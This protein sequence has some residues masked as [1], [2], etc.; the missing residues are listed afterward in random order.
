MVIVQ[1]YFPITIRPDNPRTPFDESEVI[2]S[3]TVSTEVRE[4]EWQGTGINPE[5]PPGQEGQTPPDYKDLSDFVGHLT[6]SSQIRNEAIN[7]RNTDREERPWDI[8]RATVAVAIDGVWDWNYDDQGKVILLPDGRID[9]TYTAVSEEELA[10]VDALVKDAIGY[11]QD[12]GDSVTVRHLQKDRRAQQLEEDNQFRR[13]KQAREAVLWII[14]AIG[15]AL[16]I[17]LVV[18]IFM[19]YVERK[20]REREEELARQHAAMREAA[21]RSAEEDGM[22]V[23]LSI[24]DRARVEMQENAVNIAREHPED[25][26]QLIRTWLMEE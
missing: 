3:T 17:A 23:E 19:K 7:E 14:I 24:E 2:P 13:Q 22:D 5:G 26:A 1:E 21:L 18:R 8:R 6:E 25:V 15:A 12:R 11:S 16:V 20:R 9:R 4:R 10:T